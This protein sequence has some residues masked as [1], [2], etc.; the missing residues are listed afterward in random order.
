MMTSEAGSQR[1][2]QLLP[3]FLESL[4]RHGRSPATL[5]QSV[6]ETAPGKTRS[7]MEPELD[8]QREILE[9]LNSSSLP[10]LHPSLAPKYCGAQ[11]SLP[12]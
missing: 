12:C 3:K 1:A 2:W 8:T 9:T 7:T 4:T 5:E 10:A 11:M 6:L